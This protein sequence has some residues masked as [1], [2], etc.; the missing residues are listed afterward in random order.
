M[1]RLD[2]ND[3]HYKSI[4]L[5]LIVQKI[6]YCNF[7]KNSKES[8]RLY[9][10]ANELRKDKI[11][12]D[13]RLNGIINEE[14]GKILMRQ[15]DYDK[16]LEQFKASF[17]NYQEAGNPRA[18]ILLKY[19]ILCSI[20]SRSRSNIVS[21]DEAKHYENDYQLNAMLELKDAYEHMDIS[22][23]NKIWN[24]KISK[25]EDDAFILENLNDILHNIRFNYICTK[26]KAFKIC[27]FETLEKVIKIN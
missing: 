22:S 13:I 25:K 10:E 2:Q 18:K 27:K 21:V 6:Q 26:L 15:K 20:V 4:K 7:I 24:D 9:I 14:G 11:I 17:Y 16:A 1:E 5:E 3:E 23:I 19:S 12:D 8:K